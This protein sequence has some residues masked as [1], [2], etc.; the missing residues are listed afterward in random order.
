M[1]LQVD[2]PGDVAPEFSYRVDGDFWRPFRPGPVLTVH[3]PLL[4]LVGRHTIEVRGRTTGD[5]RSLDQQPVVLTVDIQPLD[6][7]DAAGAHS[8]LDPI[9][10]ARA[11]PSANQ[12]LDQGEPRIGCA[13]AGT[14]A[15]PGLLFL[16]LGISGLM[17]MQHRRG[18]P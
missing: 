5:Y 18:K 6:H 2:R 10:P 8:A 13:T 15:T 9:A 16:L 3:D 7:P 14:A 4:N 17:V 12:A 11:H 1:L